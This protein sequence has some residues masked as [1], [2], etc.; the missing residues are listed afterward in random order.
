MVLVEVV[1]GGVVASLALRQP[2]PPVK[3]WSVLSPRIRLLE[4]WIKHGLGRLSPHVKLRT[5]VLKLGIVSTSGG[6][7]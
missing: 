2:I 5:I 3:P 7:K 6:L 4:K 1:G